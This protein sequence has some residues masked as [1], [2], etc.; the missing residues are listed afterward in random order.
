MLLCPQ[1]W[2]IN[3]VLRTLISRL[4]QGVA[5]GPRQGPWGQSVDLTPSE[6]ELHRFGGH[7]EL[8]GHLNLNLVLQL[9]C[10]PSILPPTQSP[11][12]EH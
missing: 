9:I 11:T 6:G 10:I 3:K 1:Y 8:L 4:Q 12:F 5:R 7:L 2:K